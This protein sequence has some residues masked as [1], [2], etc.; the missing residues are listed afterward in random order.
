MEYTK[1]TDHL[2]D[3]HILFKATSTVLHGSKKTREIIFE[4]EIESNR[5]K[6]LSVVDGDKTIEANEIQTTL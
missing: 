3:S 6:K 5:I 4:F 2:T 1:M